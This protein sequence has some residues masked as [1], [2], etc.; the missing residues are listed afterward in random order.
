MVTWAAV[1]DLVNRYTEE[2]IK[3]WKK[4]GVLYVENSRTN[5][6][7]PLYYQL[8]EDTLKNAARFSVEEA[9]KK[10]AIPYLII[11]GTS[12]EA[13]SINEAKKINQWNSSSEILIIEEAA[14]TFGATHPFL[15]NDFPAQLQLVL[16]NTLAFLS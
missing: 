13:V 9:A 6:Q 8:V 4:E 2:Q 7:M 1:A 5:Q 10:L 3:L 16:D 14:H 15:K 12:D 11:H